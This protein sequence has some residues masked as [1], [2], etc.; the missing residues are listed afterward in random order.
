MSKNL[1]AVLKAWEQGKAHGKPPSMKRERREFA[2]CFGVRDPC[3][4]DGRKVYSYAMM[5][6]V[7][8]D[9]GNVTVA[10]QE[11]AKRPDGGGRGGMSMTTRRHIRQV[12]WH[13]QETSIERVAWDV[14][15]DEQSHAA[16]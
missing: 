12:E 4:T 11:D 8:D 10:S 7:R 15:R 5:I 14:L 2:G 13:L 9:L 3:W 1:D 6:A 16:E